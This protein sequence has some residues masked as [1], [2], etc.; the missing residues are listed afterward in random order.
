MGTKNNDR[1][2]A[3]ANTPQLPRRK[4]TMPLAARLRIAGDDPTLDHSGFLLPL[5]WREYGELLRLLDRAME[6]E[7]AAGWS[8]RSLRDMADLLVAKQEAATA[9][10]LP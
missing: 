2:P 9:R 4:L 10:K 5:T 6:Y 8:I 7:A 3:H 1:Y